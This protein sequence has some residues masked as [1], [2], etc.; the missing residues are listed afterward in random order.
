M[1]E[2]DLPYRKGCL[3]RQTCGRFLC[4]Q[5]LPRYV[6]THLHAQGR[7]RDPAPLRRREGTRHAT[8]GAV[9][10]TAEQVSR[11]PAGPVRNRLI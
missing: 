9:L 5:L 8:M 2:M 6:P 10:R 7:G 4:L 1:A 11:E 3:K